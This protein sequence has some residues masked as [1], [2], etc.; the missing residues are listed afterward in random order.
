MIMFLSRFV[1]ILNKVGVIKFM[2]E[3]IKDML[4]YSQTR[5]INYWLKKYPL[6]NDEYGNSLILIVDNILSWLRLGY[7]REMW[8]KEKTYVKQKPLDINLKYLWCKIL[9]EL[10]ET[11][12]SF[13]EYFCITDRQFDFRE[14]VT[15]KERIVVMKLVYD[16]FQP[17]QLIN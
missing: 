8:K 11:N 5:D 2:K 1:C 9:K 12:P 7:K 3:I 4:Y 6:E 15:A 13:S 17:K 16:E 10:T 14:R